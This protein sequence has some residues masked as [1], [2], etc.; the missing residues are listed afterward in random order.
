MRKE[1]IDYVGRGLCINKVILGSERTSL[2]NETLI[3]PRTR[4]NEVY[5]YDSLEAVAVIESLI[6]SYRRG[7]AVCQG[8]LKQERNDKEKLHEKSQK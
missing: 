5:L 4:K 7:H 2:N 8:H 6:T 3:P 1:L